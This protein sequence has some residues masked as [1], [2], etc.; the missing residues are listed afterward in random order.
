MPATAATGVPSALANYSTLQ[1]WTALAFGLVCHGLFASSVVIMFYSLYTGMTSGALHLHGWKA[2]LANTLLLVQFGVLHSV[3]LSDL[4]RKWMTHLAPFGLGKP[5]S[6]TLFASIASVQLLLV[7]LLWSPSHVMWAAPQGW[8]GWI[9]TGLYAMSWGLLVK[10]MHD[11]GMD[12]QIGLLGW[13]SVWKNEHPVYKPFSRSASFSRV[14]QP[15]YLSFALILWTAPVWTPDHVF[16]A[17]L[18]TA[19]CV[20]AP[21]LKERR[22]LRFYGAAFARYQRT[23]PYWL[24]RWLPSEKVAMAKPEVT[25]FDVIII[26]AGPVG[27][28]LG[29]LLARSGKSIQILEKRSGPCL[30]SQAIGITPPSLDILSKLGLDELMKKAGVRVDKVFVH[31]ESGHLGACDFTLTQGEH[32]Y[33]LALPQRETMRLLLEKLQTYANVSVRYGVE[34]DNL[35]QQAGHVV[36]HTSGGAGL[37]SL[38]SNYVVAC[39]GSHGITRNLLKIRT[40]GGDYACNFAM[41]DFTD[42]SPFGREAH[43]FFTADGAV[44]SFP[45]PGN[46]RR[47]IV[48]TQKSED[49]PATELVANLVRQRT[50]VALNP[51]DAPSAA[52]FTPRWMRCET[53]HDGRVI[54]CG[55]AAH[56]MSPIGGQGMNTGFADAEFLAAALPTML[57]APET[58][59]SWMIFY[60]RIRSKAAATATRRA[61]LGMKLGTWK[62]VH[63]SLVRDMIMKKILFAPAFARFV[64]S[65]FSMVSIPS[66][67]LAHIP[68]RHLPLIAPQAVK[69]LG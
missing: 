40:H 4:G 35:D 36:V 50:G 32:R 59:A 17:V 54:L 41:A 1:R 58:A 51:A 34:M 46:V 27:L 6:T 67:T 64:A 47:W 53:Y 24:P 25:D 42:A 7:F 38:T 23:V 39:D 61:A 13:W 44:E 9:L 3:L 63:A 45:L 2:L 26:G 10:S 69:E 66:R 37:G 28:L 15:I 62:G 19:Y 20:A 57:A 31:G 68:C 8:P 18:W 60:D 49:N 21:L 12:V 33:V 22:Y 48:Q 30:Q 29:C 14:R 5:L 56:V 16:A 65:W 52:A 11:A 43:L 55:D